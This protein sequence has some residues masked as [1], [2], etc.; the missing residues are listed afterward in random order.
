MSEYRDPAIVELHVAEFSEAHW[1]GLD[2]V[3][4]VV[5]SHFPQCDIY[6]AKKLR[7]N[8]ERIR[9]GRFVEKKGMPLFGIAIDEDGKPF[10]SAHIDSK[11]NQGSIQPSIGT[12]RFEICK[13]LGVSTWGELAKKRF[14]LDQI[15][16]SEEVERYIGQFKKIPEKLLNKRT[17]GLGRMPIDFE[18]DAS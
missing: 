2:K 15:G 3:I 5:R 6:I 12:D 14:Y 13:A 4:S 7:G 1:S 16:N 8:K 11:K 10:F 9:M 18:K 17:A